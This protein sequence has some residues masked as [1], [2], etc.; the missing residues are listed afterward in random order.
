MNNETP[1]ENVAA[2]TVQEFCDAYRI[3]KPKFYRMVR[4]G[5]APQSIKIG[6][7]RR[8]PISA[9]KAWEERFL[10]DSVVSPEDSQA[11]RDKC[12]GA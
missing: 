6:N 1:G 10:A 3:S 8:I 7:V 9:A 12:R 5:E 2:Y 11:A 4:N